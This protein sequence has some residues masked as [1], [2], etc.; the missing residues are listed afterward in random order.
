[1]GR[2]PK[3]VAEVLATLY[4]A[5]IYQRR[6][7]EWAATLPDDAKRKLFR[8]FARRRQAAIDAGRYYIPSRPGYLRNLT[9]GAR[10]RS[11]KPCSMTALFANGR[12]I[13]HGGKSTGPRT[14][15]GRARSLENLKLGR[16][17][18]GKSRG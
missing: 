3:A 8:N 17:K 2:H 11:G 6:W 10:T 4:Q 9:C 14:A 12:C 15:E 18:R 13:W 7:E 1:M 5:T 16:R